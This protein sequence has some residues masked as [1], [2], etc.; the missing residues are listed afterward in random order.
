PWL[1]VA[2]TSVLPTWGAEAARFAPDLR[3]VTVE[4]TSVRRTRTIVQLADG[5]DVVVAPYGVVR[6]DDAEF[7]VP[8]WAGVVLDEAQFV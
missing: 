3:V 7:G 8:A 4:A 5:A 6:T 2:P 1:V